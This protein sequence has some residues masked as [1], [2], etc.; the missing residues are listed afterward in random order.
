MGEWE[1]GVADEKVRGK[2]ERGKGVGGGEGKEGREW[3]G[4]R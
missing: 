4:W 2:R 1:T 3:E